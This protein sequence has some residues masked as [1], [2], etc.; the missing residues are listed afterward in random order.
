MKLTK[1]DVAVL[2]YVVAIAAMFLV[3]QLYYSPSVTEAETIAQECVGLKQQVDELQAKVDQQPQYEKEISQM[4]EDISAVLDLYP[5]SISEEDII[6]Y[7]KELND[8][9]DMGI[10]GVT[11]SNASPIYSV[12]G[13]GH[14]SDYNFL[15][16]SIS[17][18]INYSTDYDG[19]KRIVNY[20]NDDPDHRII[21]SVSIGISP[22]DDSQITTT[23][24]EDGN[25]IEEKPD[26]I[27]G[28]LAITLYLIEGKPVKLDENGEPIIE[29]EE[30]RYEIPEV[31]H[32]VDDIFRTEGKKTS[33]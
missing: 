33:E 19:L 5:S 9:L 31:D 2:L 7:V 18:N 28:S 20:I 4:K 25:V 13:T 29:D 24:D 26:T 27:T 6:L 16:E 14:A 15:A 12:V 17:I 3:Y 10:N 1:R 30:T 32:G 11:F 23:T 21:N 22:L 8:E